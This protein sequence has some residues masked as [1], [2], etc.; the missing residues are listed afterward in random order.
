MPAKK[1]TAKKKTLEKKS[2]RKAI[3]LPQHSPEL[4]FSDAVLAGNTLYLSGRLGLDPA[5]GK[6]P[7]DVDREIDFLLDGFEAVLKQ[8]GLGWDELVW[9]QIFSSDLSLWQQ[10]NAKYVKRFRGDLPARA[11]LSCPPLLFNGRFEMMGIAMK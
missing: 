5:T 9:V 1:R 10:F 11:F 2:T 8:S 6:V 3:N 7:P 4:P